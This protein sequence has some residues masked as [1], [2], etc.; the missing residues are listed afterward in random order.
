MDRKNVWLRQRSS[1]DI[2]ANCSMNRETFDRDDIGRW[3][4]HCSLGVRGEVVRH[5]NSRTRT[6]SLI[7]QT[8]FKAPRDQTYHHLRCSSVKCE[9]VLSFLEPLRTAGSSLVQTVF[10]KMFTISDSIRRIRIS[11]SHALLVS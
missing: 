5:S 8:L 3:R 2:Q 4:L 11:V 7:W 6:F 10:T 1:K 9:C